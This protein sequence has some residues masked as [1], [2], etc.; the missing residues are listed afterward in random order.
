MLQFRTYFHPRGTTISCCMCSK[1]AGNLFLLFSMFGALARVVR[2][3]YGTKRNLKHANRFLSLFSQVCF[4]LV[5]VIVQM[6]IM[7]IDLGVTPPNVTHVLHYDH[8]SGH[9]HLG[10]PEFVLFCVEGNNITT[11]LSLIYKTLI[12]GTA[13]VLGVLSFKLPD[14]FN[15]A[16]YISF[17]TFALLVVWIG[18]VPTYFATRSNPEIHSAA[19][20]LCL[21]F[22]PLLQF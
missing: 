18:L 21:S 5:I 22:S 17:C 8:E 12:I 9:E 13:T 4:T 16:K 14:N 1:S 20:H 3:F 19:V 6:C 2:I 15:E 10:F 11:V 7:F